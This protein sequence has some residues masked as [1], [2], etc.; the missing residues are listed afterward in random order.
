[1]SAAIPPTPNV[2]VLWLDQPDA[3]A[4]APDALSINDVAQQLR[5]PARVI[6]G[7]QRRGLLAPRAGE[8]FVFDR[9]DVRRIAAVANARR[10]G[11]TLAEIKHMFCAEEGRAT[12]RVLQL[13][14]ERCMQRIETLTRRRVEI[15]RMLGQLWQVHGRL[16][17]RLAANRHPAT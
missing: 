14:R 2:D 10:L 3:D 6:R 12:P 4:Q 17:D 8:S 15:E 16:L 7:Y 9:A 1:M 5:V 11:F 13:N